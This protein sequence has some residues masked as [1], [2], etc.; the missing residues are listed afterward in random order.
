MRR[1]VYNNTL[2]SCEMGMPV[3]IPPTGAVFNGKWR[4]GAALVGV[5][6]HCKCTQVVICC[7]MS[8]CVGIG[9]EACAVSLRE[10][11][12]FGIVVR[13]DRAPVLRVCLVSETMLLSHSTLF[14]VRACGR[15]E[16]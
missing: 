5:K 2:K 10:L 14:E 16:A 12:A 4:R 1:F 8:A 15:V 6:A 3:F 13:L 11:K 9:E 7:R